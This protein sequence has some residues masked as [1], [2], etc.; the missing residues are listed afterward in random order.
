MKKALLFLAALAGIA[1]GVLV[2]RRRQA[3][4]AVPESLWTNAPGNGSTVHAATVPPAA[5]P[6]VAVTTGDEPLAMSAG[7]KEPKARPAKARAPKAAPAGDVSGRETSEEA[8]P[9]RAK[10]ASTRS[11]GGKPAATKPSEKRATSPAAGTSEAEA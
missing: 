3:A 6:P 10:P 8:K 9:A 7:K 11:S 5:A 4:P 1:A 2:W